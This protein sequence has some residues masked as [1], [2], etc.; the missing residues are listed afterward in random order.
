[1]DLQQAASCDPSPVPDED[2]RVV[3]DCVYVRVKD[4]STG[5]QELQTFRK[6]IKFVA[7]TTEVEWRAIMACCVPADMPALRRALTNSYVTVISNTENL[8]DVLAK[9]GITDF[10][11][12]IRGKLRAMPT[13]VPKPGPSGNPWNKK[14]NA[15]KKPKS[16]GRAAAVEA[17]VSEVRQALSGLED[18]E[19]RAT[20]T[21]NS[22]PAP[23]TPPAHAGEVP[24][25][26]HSSSPDCAGDSLAPTPL[27]PARAAL[28]YEEAVKISVQD[29]C[30]LLGPL[31]T[32]KRPRLCSTAVAVPP[33][34]DSLDTDAMT[35]Y[36]HSAA[37]VALLHVSRSAE[38]ADLKEFGL[39]GIGV[40]G[41]EFEVTSHGTSF[42]GRLFFLLEGVALPAL[43]E[44]GNFYRHH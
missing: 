43:L 10:R 19:T 15:T 42:F 14:N 34:V 44:V 8:L 35:L 24:L 31:S 37:C 11:E 6:L 17:N 38:T 29:R 4:L 23:A 7:F 36:V 32:T 28:V 20:P 30:K 27:P 16:S 13:E 22:S 2:A 39:S 9:S 5:R 41:K 40:F 18:A 33:A 3:H 25:E 21:T 1:V 12:A 26:T